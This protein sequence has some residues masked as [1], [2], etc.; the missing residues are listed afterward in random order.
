MPAAFE[1]DD[2]ALLAALDPD[3]VTPLLAIPALDVPL[4]PVEIRRLTHAVF[5]AI[6]LPALPAGVQV[7]ERPRQGDVPPVRVY[8][9]TDRWRP[10][11]A[12]MWIHGGGLIAGGARY[13]DLLCARMAVEHGCAV[14]SVDYRLAPESPYPCALDDCFAALTWMLDAPE[15][16]VDAGQV[17]VTGGSAGG[18][19]AIALALLARD[20]GLDV[21]RALVCPYP[22]LDDRPTA[23]MQRLTAR[24]AWHRDANRVA[25]QA[26]LGH[27]AEIPIYAAPARASVDELRG[28]PPIALDVGTL[29]GF[30]DEVVALA[31]R[32]AEADVAVDLVVT[33]GACHGSEHVNV[34][35]PTSRR[36]LAARHAARERALSPW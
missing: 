7:E 15:V 31:S 1:L 33:P 17:V 6:E 3:C 27:L 4:D 12:L 25:W 14:V 26:Y 30:R 24:R 34:E 5:D 16:G 9:P 19:L 18:G 21:I 20:R 2:D 29:D 36:I 22:M 11:S 8:V 13:D 23:S 10:R 28:L 32:L 35:A